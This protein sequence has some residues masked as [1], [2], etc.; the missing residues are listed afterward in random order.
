[1]SDASGD[2]EGQ[3]KPSALRMVLVALPLVIIVALGSVFYFRLY[4]GNPNVVPS[5]L[6]NAPAPSFELPALVTADN[7]QIL[8]GLTTA[9]LKGEPT[10]VN[11]WASWCGPCREEMPYLVSLKEQGVRIY[12]INYKDSA[13]NAIRFL[14]RYGNPFDRIGV[15]QTGRTSIDWGVYGVPETFIIDA[16]GVIIHK[17]IGPF[18]ETHVRDVFLPMIRGE[19]SGEPQQTSALKN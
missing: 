3:T 6:I 18:N 13:A 8:P 5:A 2:Q 4:G 17:H 16:D 7:A 19:A 15:D 14:S 11:V 10:I 12:G 1:M 9:D